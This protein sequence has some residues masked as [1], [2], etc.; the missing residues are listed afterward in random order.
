MRVSKTCGDAADTAKM[1]LDTLNL[2][3]ALDALEADVRT[4]TFLLSRLKKLFC[5]FFV[6]LLFYLIFYF[7]TIYFFLLR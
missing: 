3:A 1:A 6:F 5:Y 4:F 7:V 2:P